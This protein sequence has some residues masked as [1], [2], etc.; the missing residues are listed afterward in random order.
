MRSCMRG[1]WGNEDGETGRRGDVKEYTEYT[2]YMEYAEF[3][4]NARRAGRTQV[5][6]DCSYYP[7]NLPDQI[8]HISF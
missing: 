5:L 1:V 2:E 8:L 3:G 6:R 7:P 4:L